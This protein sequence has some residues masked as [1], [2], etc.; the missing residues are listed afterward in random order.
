MIK[1]QK[2]MKKKRKK[3]EKL[4]FFHG[5][6]KTRDKILRQRIFFEESNPCSMIGGI[7]TKNQW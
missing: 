4:F 6:K 5:E 1:K 3:N 2:K 7:T